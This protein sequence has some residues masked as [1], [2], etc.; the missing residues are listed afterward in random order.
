MGLLEPISG[1]LGFFLLV[2]VQFRAF[3]AS[4]APILGLL[5]PIGHFRASFGPNLDLLEP[6]SGIVG[7]FLLVLGLLNWFFG[8]FW[9]FL[10]LF[11]S[12]L[13]NLSSL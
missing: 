10:E 9:P 5:E 12:N 13:G 11:E 1:I 7:L 4:F 2:L 8:Q 3:S 6:I